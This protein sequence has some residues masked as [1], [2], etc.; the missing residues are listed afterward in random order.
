VTDDHDQI[1]TWLERDINPLM[2]RQGTL[3]RIRRTA[4]RRKTTQAIVT[5]AG[6]AVVIAAVAVVP[7]LVHSN[8]NTVASHSTTPATHSQTATPSTAPSTKPA[9]PKPHASASTTSGTTITT[10]GAVPTTFHPTSVTFVG[11]GET[12]VGAVIGQ[13]SNGGP[14]PCATRYC[15]SLAAT[16][17]YGGSWYGV[18]AP[19][20]GP[21]HGAAG[22]SQLRFANTSDG[23]AYGPALFATRDGGA[24]WI[25][26]KTFGMR[27]VALEAAQG[28][29]FAIFARCIGTTADFASD[30]TSF[31][32]YTSADGT[33]TWAPAAVA[34]AFQTMSTAEPS[35]ASLTI[36]GNTGY[37]LGPSGQLLRGNLTTGTW[38]HVGSAQ[39][40]PGGAQASGLPLNAHLATLGL[41]GAAQPTLVLACDAKSSAIIYT[42]PTGRVW[43]KAGVASIAGQA[44]SIASDASGRLVLGTTAGIYYSANQGATW[45]A[46]RFTAGAPPGGFSYVGMTNT[47]QAVAI[48]ADASLGE[49][50]VSASGGLTWQPS[51]IRG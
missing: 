37:V 45:Q 6:C 1:D 40:Q 29:A 3:D 43:T 18:S 20:T 24:H 38:T 17:T 14:H 39:C 47:K 5:A 50:F 41:L 10:G 44:T 2:P 26:E 7:Q 32:L 12:L 51:A 22:V 13:G 42:S 4:R 21:P 33:T 31:S 49:V 35:S 36:A 28:H 25:A 46:A 48:P 27:V 19:L 16:T 15:T 23:W 30:C 8:A 9:S 11:F 34:T